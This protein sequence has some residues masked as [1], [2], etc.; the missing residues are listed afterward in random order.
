VESNLRS[1]L[2]FINDIVTPTFVIEGQAGGNASSIALLQKKSAG[3]PPIH[4]LL[5]PGATHFSQLASSTELV[6]RKILADDGASTGISLTA[7]ELGRAFQAAGL[8]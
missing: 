1:P 5:V 4:F 8:K 7:D 6:A 2:T 3:G